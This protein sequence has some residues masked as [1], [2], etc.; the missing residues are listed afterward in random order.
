MFCPILTLMF[1]FGLPSVLEANGPDPDSHSGVISFE[2]PGIVV[3]EKLYPKL[4]STLNQVL[5]D[6]SESVGELAVDIFFSGDSAE[7]QQ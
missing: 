2:V 1:L 6:E 7:I 5:V 4:D 3:S